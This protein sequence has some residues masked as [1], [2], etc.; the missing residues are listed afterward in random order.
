MW[1]G[2]YVGG[3]VGGWLAD[4]FLV[5]RFSLLPALRAALVSYMVEVCC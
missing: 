2:G 1:A 3:R 4:L 5:F